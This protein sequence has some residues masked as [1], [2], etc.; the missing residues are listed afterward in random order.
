MDPGNRPPSVAGDPQR[1]LVA[2]PPATLQPLVSVL[3]QT[4]D[5]TVVSVRLNSSGDPER[6]VV[7]MTPPRAAALA[8]ALADLIVEPDEELTHFS[9][10]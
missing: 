10:R 3:E 1:F 6:L 8:I 9:P 4:P 7:T 5:I 2:G